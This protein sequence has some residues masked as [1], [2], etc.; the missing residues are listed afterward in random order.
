[1][2]VSRRD[3]LL[4]TAG[5]TAGI[6]FTPVPWKVLDDVSI[7]T[8]NWP[9]IPQP[10]HG[11][12]T[13]KLAS[14]TLCTSAC[15]MRV[16]MAGGF[17]VG[18]AGVPSHPMTKGALCPLGFAAHQLNWHPARLREVRHR[19]RTASWQEAKA[20]FEK[21]SSEGSIAIIDGRSDRG[22]ST[23]L[24]SFAAKHNGTYQV[25]LNNDERSLIPYAQ[26]SGIAVSSLG[27]DLENAQT[28]VSFG[29]PLL[30][31]W[32]IPGRF[33]HLWSE[34]AA[35]KSDP[36]LRL[37]QIEPTFTRTSSGAWRWVPICQGT[38]ALLAAVLAKVLIGEHL[39]AARGPMPPASL[40]EAAKQTG[41]D[42]TA[43][44]ELAY[45][46]VE[47]RPTLVLGSDENP[48]VAALNVL[49]GSVGAPGGIVPRAASRSAVPRSSIS[50]STPRAILLDAS[51]P[52]DYVPSAG[53][54]VF[55]F[56]AWDG[57]GSR[58]DWLL[59][60]P[61]FLE[62]E[63][64][65]PTPATSA[66]AT[67]GIARK[68]ITPSAEL[69]T[70]AEFLIQIDPSLPKT[71]AAIHARCEEIFRGRRGHVYGEKASP[72]SSFE[73]AAK[74]EEALRAGANWLDNVLPAATLK[75]TLPE[76]PTDNRAHGRANWSDTWAQP[77]MP[78]LAA[79]LYR[80][81]SLREPPQGSQS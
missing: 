52:W 2:K 34:R 39:V 30:D 57:G 5:L 54:E 77:V 46:M 7:W 35:G 58:A 29:A 67:Y 75:C 6:M 61:G 32:G 49:L 43:I 33:T 1:M 40:T 9:W 47:R 20:A 22:A 10:A 51:V 72:V 8:Q 78:T 3:L 50:S 56:A 63:V 23:A 4:G 24:Q 65:L 42:E 16:R 14:C 18:V 79:K 48:S 68:L 62:E 28:V 41:L 70:A 37:I 74:L 76:W 53:A 19:G 27:Y 80:E 13:T 71:E 59:P 81:S 12:V 21:A 60:A 11:P 55:R 26:W 17:P 38:E 25:A 69:K 36:Q 15:P 31:G 64:D 66:V 73:S 45:S 44:R